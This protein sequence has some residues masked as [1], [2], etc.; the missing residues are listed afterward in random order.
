MKRVI[1]LWLPKFATDRLCRLRQDWLDSPI[2]LIREDNGRLVLYAVNDTAEQAGIYAGMTLTDARAILPN[3]KTSETDLPAETK[4]LCRLADWCGRFT[5]WTAPDEE[6]SG[7][8]FAGVRIPA[9]RDFAD[10]WVRSS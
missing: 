9:N 3:L 2:G 7:N 6:G 1:S 5:P 4:A 10:S 8:A